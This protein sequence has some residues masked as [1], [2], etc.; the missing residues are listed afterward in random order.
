MKCSFCQTE[1][2]DGTKYCRKC[3]VDLVT[4]PLWK[5]TWIWHVKVLGVIY[6][7]LIVAYFAISQFLKRVPEPYRMRDVPK[8]ITPWLKK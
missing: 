8:D 5:P 7:V 2:K 6:V 3:G 1:N 4:D